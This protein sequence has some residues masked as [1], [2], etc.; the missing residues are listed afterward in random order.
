LLNYL[1]EEEIEERLDKYLSKISNISRVEIQKLIALKQIKVNDEVITLN[2]FKIKNGDKIQI[3]SRINNEITIKPENIDIPIV[4]E[5]DYLLVIN[6]PNNMVVHPAPGNYQGTLVN[7]L[8]FHF[9]KLSDVNGELRP[10]IV[11]RLDKQTTGLLVVA[12]DNDTHN[13]LAKQ[14]KDHSITREYIAIVEGII[15]N[16][17]THINLP[18]GRNK[19]HRQKMSVRYDD[20]K[21]AMTHVFIEKQLPQHTVVRCKL[22]TG[23]THQIRVHLAYIKHPV[24]GD[25]KYGKQL[26]T[27]GQYLHA[28]KLSFTH[29]NGKKMTFNAP[30]PKEFVNKIK[31]LS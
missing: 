6:K 27:F 29:P 15:T 11:H 1:V 14:L 3:L 28:E 2:K 17:I 23:R 13:F 4:Y 31:E 20:S 24:L 16:D 22:E 7:A 19:T 12:K 30:L 8:L 21:K 9:K 25:S 18:I 10:G 5:D 26:D